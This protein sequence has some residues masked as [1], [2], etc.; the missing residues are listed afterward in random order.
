MIQWHDTTTSTQVR[1]I[2]SPPKETPP[3]LALT[4]ASSFREPLATTHLPS[5]SVGLPVPSNGITAMELDD[6]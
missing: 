2:C 5:V 6:A 1:D 3:P 4:P